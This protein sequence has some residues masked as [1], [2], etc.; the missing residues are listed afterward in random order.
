MEP[1]TIDIDRRPNRSRLVGVMV[2]LLGLAGV[3]WS[4]TQTSQSQGVSQT[5]QTTEKFILVTRIDETGKAQL[6]PL[7]CSGACNFLT[8]DQVAAVAHSGGADWSGF[9]GG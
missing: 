9:K 1:R 6:E 3:F 7:A 4:L 2:L 5:P 8:A